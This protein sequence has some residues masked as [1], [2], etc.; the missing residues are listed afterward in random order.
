MDFLTP[1]GV[2]LGPEDMGQNLATGTPTFDPSFKPAK[3]KDPSTAAITPN[4]IPGS[5]PAPPVE[6]ALELG[7]LEASPGLYEYLAQAQKGADYLFRLSSELQTE[8]HF[9]RAL[10]C[11][12]RVIDSADA[13]PEDQLRA[14]KAIAA[15]APTL[16]PW[17]VDP[18]A[19]IPLKMNLGSS[20]ETD[21]FIKNAALKLATEIH[22]HS[23]EQIDVSPVI[24][25]GSG[26]NAIE[27][28]PIAIWFTTMGDESASTAVLSITPK[29]KDPKVLDNELALTAYRL[30]RAYLSRIGYSTESPPAGISGSELLSHHVT[31]RMWY[32]FAQ[33]LLNEQEANKEVRD[34]QEVNKIQE[35]A[36]ATPVPE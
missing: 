21:D 17:N 4:N 34:A 12:E 20:R 13:K 15:L 26:A 5:D 9:Q 24:S 8:G 30:V 27:N 2:V 19:I 31:R 35:A 18:S 6:E 28:G 7:D 16:P 14:V 32:D 10:L 23:G 25:S 11:L 29:T 22:K 1:K 3:I 36:K 33:T